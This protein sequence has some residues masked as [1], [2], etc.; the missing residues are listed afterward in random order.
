[1][2]QMLIFSHSH[3]INN[4]S[5]Q[6]R[7]L[8]KFQWCVKMFQKIICWTLKK[9]LYFLRWWWSVSTLEGFAGIQFPLYAHPYEV[10]NSFPLLWKFHNIKIDGKEDVNMHAW[11][12]SKNLINKSLKKSR[13]KP[14]FFLLSSNVASF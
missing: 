2:L 5:H 12:R 3:H 8:V 7:V 11:M 14:F 1:M 9:K 4:S 6:Y 10:S 13:L